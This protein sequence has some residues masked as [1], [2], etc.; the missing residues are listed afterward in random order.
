MKSKHPT[1]C[2]RRAVFRLA[3]EPLPEQLVTDRQDR[4]ADAANGEHAVGGDEQATGPQAHYGQADYPG[5]NTAVANHSW[6]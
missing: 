1:V 3:P 2:G 4:R 6:R 5:L